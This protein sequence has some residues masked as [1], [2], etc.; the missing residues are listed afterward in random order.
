MTSW[1][2]YN[3]QMW[4]F[5]RQSCPV[6]NMDVHRNT[7]YLM[8]QY[9]G[10]LLWRL[11]YVWRCAVRVTVAKICCPNSKALSNTADKCVLPFLS[12]KDPS[13]GSAPA[14][15]ISQDSL[16]AIDQT[17]SFRF[18]L[19]DLPS[20]RGWRRPTSFICRVDQRALNLD[21]LCR[22]CFTKMGTEQSSPFFS[23]TDIV[24]VHS[25]HLI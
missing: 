17:G 16:R 7:F 24:L 22:L 1:Q 9:R 19:P 18:G 10:R 25:L 5:S 14:Q 21:R 15:T 13:G 3:Y 20:L 23:L 11:Q 2:Y 8:S 6:I 4:G 12:M